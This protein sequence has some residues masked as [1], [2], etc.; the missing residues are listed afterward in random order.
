LHFG[1]PS[2]TF[3]EIYGTSFVCWLN[4][5][6][7]LIETVLPITMNFIK[8]L[9]FANLDAFQERAD[10]PGIRVLFPSVEGDLNLPRKHP[11][12]FWG[13]HSLL[14]IGYLEVLSQGN[15]AVNFI[16]CRN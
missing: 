8:D 13:P 2:L 9:V 11:F 14:P 3:L 10:D 15:C 6:L 4:I 12:L 5:S 1:L 7:G 16:S